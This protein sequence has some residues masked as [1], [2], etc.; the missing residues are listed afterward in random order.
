MIRLSTTQTSSQCRA[1]LNATCFGRCLEALLVNQLGPLHNLTSLAEHPI[2][3]RWP[4]RSQ[5]KVGGVGWVIKG[6]RSWTIP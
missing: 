2:S 1:Q 6:Q 4:P 3:P 5:E